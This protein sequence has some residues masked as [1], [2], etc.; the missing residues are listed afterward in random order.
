MRG[1]HQPSRGLFGEK[2]KCFDPPLVHS[3]F[4]PCNWSLSSQKGNAPHQVSILLPD[5]AH[6][7]SAFVYHPKELKWRRKELVNSEA[8]STFF[9]ATLHPGQHTPRDL[10]SGS[11]SWACSLDLQM[12]STPRPLPGL[13]Q[14]LPTARIP[15]NVFLAFWPPFQ[16]C[17][18]DFRPPFSPWKNGIFF[19]LGTGLKSQLCQLGRAP[20][21]SPRQTE[22]RGA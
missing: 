5:E 12:S 9:P 7:C 10:S 15:L 11:V 1:P 17:A 2:G 13:W 16:D 3:I 19:C 8:F 18:V 14:A 21:S 22:P 20:H 6:H 4:S